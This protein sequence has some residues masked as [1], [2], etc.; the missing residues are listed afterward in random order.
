MAA[1]LAFL[2]VAGADAGASG[3]ATRDGVRAAPITLDEAWS[4]AL[5]THEAPKM[6]GEAAEQARSTLGKAVSTLL[7]TVTAEAAYTGFSEEKSVSGFLVQPEDSTK[8]DLRVVQPLYTGGREWAARRQARVLLDE[9]RA[10][11][12]AAREDLMLSVARS[13]YGLLKAERELEI[14]NAAKRRAEERR[15]AADAVF[16]AGAAPRAAVLRAEAEAAA[17]DAGVIMAAS[18]VLDAKTLLKRLTGADSDVQAVEPPAPRPVVESV[19]ELVAR[20]TV[21]H[22]AYRM[23][24]LLERAAGEGTSFARSAFFPSVRLEGLYSWRDQNPETSFFQEDSLSASIVVSYPIFEGG[25]RR[26][27]VAEAGSRHREAALKALSIRRDIEVR[28]REAYN[29]MRSM[30]AVAEAYKRQLLYSEE[31]YAMVFEQFRLGL[32][33]TVDVIDSDANLI[34]AQRSHMNAGYDHA[35]TVIEL[36]HA[37]GSLSGLAR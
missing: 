31:D 13:F 22:K 33:T 29:R 24:Q 18:A 34:S 5:S 21:N 28:V 10:G 17:A 4:M 7:P 15:K 37:V 3:N 25:L 19:E 36:M 8:F 16:R 20:A 32:A 23:A 26:A 35:L 9:R 6:A 11:M 1:A 27:E 14:K 30:K 2:P 12:E